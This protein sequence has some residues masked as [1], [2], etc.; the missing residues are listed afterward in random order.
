[1]KKALLITL[2]FFTLSSSL[3]FAAPQEKLD[4][5]LQQW[6]INGSFDYSLHHH[7]SPQLLSE[8][9]MPQ[10]QTM[11]IIK[12]NYIIDSKNYMRFQYGFTSSSN[13]GRGSDSDW[14]TI[15]SNM[16]TDY[17]TMDFTGEQKIVDITLGTLLAKS[18]NNNTTLLLGWRK[19]DTR[20]ELRNVVY[21]L[22]NGVNVGNISQPDNGS[23]LNGTFSGLHIGVENDYKINNKMSLTSSLTTSFLNTKA[24]GHWANHS[25]A[26]DWKNTGQTLGYDINLSLKYTVN[27][28]IKAEL[29]YYYAY[30]KMLH[31]NETLNFNNGSTSTFS[32][33]DLGYVQRGFY[34]GLTSR[35]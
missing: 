24:Y 31:G 22:D 10:N 4:L 32:G 1:M 23:Y 29:G 34:S 7:G 2:G 27:K 19:R 8:I 11:G 25:P 20:N 26:W 21:H 5:S 6:N 16:K 15:G 12:L 33:I 9:S 18:K 17:G 30:A 28:N 3:S 35:F 14:Q 13:K